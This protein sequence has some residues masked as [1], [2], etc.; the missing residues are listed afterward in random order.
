[1]R[2]INAEKRPRIRVRVLPPLSTL[3]LVVL[4]DAW[5]HLTHCSIEGPFLCPLSFLKY[6]V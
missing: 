4:V 1:M 2:K 3:S 6:P 5:H